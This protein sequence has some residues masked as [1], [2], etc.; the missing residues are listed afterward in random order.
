MNV[1][2]CALVG[3]DGGRILGEDGSYWQEQMCFVSPE[4]YKIFYTFFN[5]RR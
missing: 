1:G 4:A 5:N 2:G 3:E